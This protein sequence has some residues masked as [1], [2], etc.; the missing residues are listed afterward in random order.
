MEFLKSSKQRSLLS[1]SIFIVLN[2][3]LALGVFALVLAI[4]TPLPA[5]GLVL[6]S[7]WRILAVRP[8]YWFAN[9]QSNLVDLIVNLGVVIMLWTAS[10]A[11][12]AQ[13]FI[14][15]LYIVWLLF[16]KPRSKRMFVA[17]QAGTAVFVGFIALAQISYGWIATVVVAITWIIGYAAARHVLANH[18][19]L[20]LT[21][22][23]M[24]W[25]LVMAELGWITYHWTRAYPIPGFGA[26]QLAQSAIIALGLSFLAERIYSSYVRQ[27]E[28]IRSVE[29]ILPAL[30]TTS[31]ILILVMFF[32]ALPA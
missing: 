9:L 22:Y 26:L 12:F 1:E 32:N 30:L 3:V 15:I 4:Q 10:G 31:V 19:E 25:G 6:L 5:I 14:T 18:S 16:I 23:S 2:I 20:H 24:I 17:A 21:F 28:G 29:V 7:K 8:R 11:L 27:D 13:I